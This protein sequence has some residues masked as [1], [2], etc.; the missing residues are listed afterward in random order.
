MKNNIRYKGNINNTS[1][2]I[3][4]NWRT[5]TPSDVTLL[6]RTSSEVFVMLVAHS[7]FCSSFCCYSSFCCCCSS[8]I[9][10]YLFVVVLHSLLFNVIAHHSVDYLRVFTPILYFQPSPSQSYS[11]HFHVQPSRDLLFIVLPRALLF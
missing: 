4:F 2:I 9:L 8:F 7:Y 10:F 6:G 11:R 1:V 5:K 3:F